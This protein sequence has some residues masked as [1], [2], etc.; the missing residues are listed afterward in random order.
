MKDQPHVLEKHSELPRTK[1]T[2]I[3]LLDDRQHPW[4]AL[5]SPV[6][7]NSEIDFLWK[8]VRL[9]RRSQC[10]DDIGRGSA[11]VLKDGY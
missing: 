6:S 7:A 5:L 10:E 1:S 3:Y 9:I 4:L 8:R 2:K 11:H